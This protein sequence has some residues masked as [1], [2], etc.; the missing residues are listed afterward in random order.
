MAR[1]SRVS[2]AFEQIIPA[3]FLGRRPISGEDIRVVRKLRRGGG[4]KDRCLMVAEIAAAG[5]EIL[6]SR[7]GLNSNHTD[8]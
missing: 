7:Y 1:T 6:S 3:R 5:G 4:L 2:D 8:M